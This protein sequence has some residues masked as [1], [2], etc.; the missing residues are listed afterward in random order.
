LAQPE[1]QKI[2]RDEQRREQEC[3][4]PPGRSVLVSVPVRVSEDEQRA[5]CGEGDRDDEL[6]GA[7][8]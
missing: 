4:D 8:V 7:E 2:E 1:A 6:A 5:A 3:A